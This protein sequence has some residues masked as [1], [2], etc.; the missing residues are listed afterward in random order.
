MIGNKVDLEQQREISYDEAKFYADKEK[1]KYIETSA[2]KNIR[3]EEV[4]SS[5]LNNI[6][7]IKKEENKNGIFGRK[8]RA[9]LAS[10]S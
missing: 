6:Y 7:E 10:F 5:L 9:I 3:V 8:I 4:F 1:I 2:I